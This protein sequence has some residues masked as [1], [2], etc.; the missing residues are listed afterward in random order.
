M[1]ASP[2]EPLGVNVSQSNGES[3]ASEPTEQV[4]LTVVVATF[5]SADHIEACLSSVGR[6][7]P[8]AEII[9]VDNGSLDGTC[10]IVRDSFPRAVVLSGHGNVGFGGACNLGAEHASHRH[11]L[12]LNPDAE[13]VAVDPKGLAVESATRPFGMLAASLLKDGAPPRSTLRRQ[14]SFWLEEFLAVHLLA[15]LSPLAPRPR[16]VERANGRGTYTVG[17]AAF[18]VAAEEFRSL[19]GFDERFFMYYEDTDLTQRYLLGGYPLRSSPALLVSHL[20]GGSAPVP[21]RNALSFLGWLEYLDKW[22]GP[23]AARRGAALAR[24]TYSLALSSLRL[25]ATVSGNARARLKAEQVA[26]MLAHVATA[27]SEA[28]AA[29]ARARYPAAAPIARSKFRSWLRRTPER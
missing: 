13:L 2:V 3:D 19:G 21:R 28:G 16:Y 5:N 15:M 10:E 23:G 25:L 20:G 9:V 17:G 27:G 6:C 24:V 12:C 14:S 4:A 18:M 11:V 22:H 7:L 8:A 1:E 29:G 26:A